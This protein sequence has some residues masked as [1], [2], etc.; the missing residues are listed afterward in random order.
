MRTKLLLVPVVVAAALLLSG[1]ALAAAPPTLTGEM[2]VSGTAATADRCKVPA[3]AE[4]VTFIAPLPAPT[5]ERTPR[6]SRSPTA[7]AAGCRPTQRD[8]AVICLRVPGVKH[9]AILRLDDGRRLCRIVY[10]SHRKPLPGHPKPLA[11]EAPDPVKV[12]V[13]VVEAPIDQEGEMRAEFMSI[14][15]AVVTYLEGVTRAWQN[16]EPGDRGACRRR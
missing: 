5:R 11:E 8:I 10:L 15:E 9:A 13:E 4:T 6:R 16:A 7:P 1:A 12:L 2:F 3:G 14:E